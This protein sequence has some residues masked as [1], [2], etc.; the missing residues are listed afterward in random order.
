MIKNI[1]RIIIFSVLLVGCSLPGLG[2]ASNN[3]IVIAS[4]NTTERQISAELIKQMINHYDDGI[5]VDILNNL[6][7]SILVHQA[8]LRNDA[9]ISAIMYSGTSLTGELNMEPTSNANEAFEKVVRAYATKFSMIWMPSY[10]FSN[11]YTFMVSREFAEHNNVSK[12]SDL[13]PLAN[14][15][16]AGVDTSWMEREGDGYAD[17][18]R[19]YNFDFSSVLPM[20]IGLVYNA[21]NSGYVDVVLGYSTDGRIEAYDLVLLEDDLNLF[22][23]YDASMVVRSEVF[24]QY[25]H[26]EAVLLRLENSLDVST[27]QKLNR[28]SDEMQIEPKVVAK[29]FLEANNFF[30][31]VAVKSLSER[32]LY[33]PLLGGVFNDK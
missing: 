20:E 33:K 13:A 24:E 17:F 15:L 1:V 26:L 16:V 12:I 21:V 23:P 19:M 4:G 32:E 9:Q 7:S 3:D 18:I 25:P 31:H 30:E 6:G 11:T 29:Q 28:M 10:G 2:G 22:P 14:D 5:D 27:M 8:L